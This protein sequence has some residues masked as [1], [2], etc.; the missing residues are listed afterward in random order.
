MRMP[1]GRSLSEGG[2][3]WEYVW[4]AGYTTE[5]VA[6]Q[7]VLYRPDCIVQILILIYN[8]AKESF[9]PHRPSSFFPL[10]LPLPFY[11]RYQ[12]VTPTL[13]VSRYLSLLPNLSVPSACREYGVHLGSSWKSRMAVMVFAEST[14]KRW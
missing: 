10:L 11:L 1:I 4:T 8:N 2:K 12:A 9:P 6:F 5:I 14:V 13:T 7:N 3:G